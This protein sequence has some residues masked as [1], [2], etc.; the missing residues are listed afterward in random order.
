MDINAATGKAI[1]AERAIA[2]MTVRELS[3]KANIPLSSLMR[4]LQAEREIKINQI[5]AIAAALDLYPHDIVEHAERILERENRTAPIV[6]LP[7]PPHLS[8]VPD[9]VAA[10]RNDGTHRE[11]DES[12][13]DD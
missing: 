6:K 2:G 5:A 1:S 4:V 11:F 10:Y 13:W 7:V 12:Q 3:Q 9:S 8:V